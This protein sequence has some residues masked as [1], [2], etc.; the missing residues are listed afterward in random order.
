M[1]KTIKASILV[2]MS[3]AAANVYAQGSSA[4]A[5][6]G[7]P[8]VMNGAKTA[9]TPVAVITSTNSDTSTS[10]TTIS[11]NPETTSTTIT[12]GANPNNSSEVKVVVS[13][14]PTA[15][16]EQPV[17]SNIQSNVV[18]KP[19]KKPLKSKSKAKPKKRTTA[20]ALTIVVAQKDVPTGP[21]PEELA[22]IARK[23]AIALAAAEEANRLKA[24]QTLKQNLPSLIF[25]PKYL[26]IV[27]ATNRLYSCN[28]KEAC[29]MK[30]TVKILNSS[31]DVSYKISGLFS[32]NGSILNLTKTFDPADLGLID[33]SGFALA[34][35]NPYQE[36]LE[37]T[38][39]SKKNAKDK[40]SIILSFTKYPDVIL[41]IP[42]FN[43]NNFVGS[44]RVSGLEF[45]VD[46]TKC[47]FKLTNCNLVVGG[48]NYIL[49]WDTLNLVANGREI[50]STKDKSFKE[51]FLDNAYSDY[52]IRK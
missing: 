30:R 10:Q 48:K 39:R 3:T 15:L 1:N 21:T 49:S 5:E 19:F 32:E 36:V 51:F 35:K 46:H 27:E 4:P 41:N 25:L 23:D 16:K 52:L 17:Q 34:V 20:E 13:T 8:I 11:T 18:S 26:E 6:L 29:E 12:T 50:D 7:Q 38:Y 37:S 47:N 40:N 31:F 9:E 24:E 28:G 22:E 45:L 33:N 44:F 14:M 42:L 43:E 2:L